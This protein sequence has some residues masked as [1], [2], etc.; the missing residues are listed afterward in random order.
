MH[1]TCVKKHVLF[2]FYNLLCH[3]SAIRPSLRFCN[4]AIALSTF[5]NWWKIIFKEEEKSRDFPSTV[6]I[7]FQTPLL[8]PISVGRFWCHACG[9][10][11]MLFGG[12][13]RQQG[14]E[15][16]HQRSKSPWCYSYFLLT[17]KKLPLYSCLC[18]GDLPNQKKVF[19]KSGTSL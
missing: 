5:C 13:W 17:I 2:L 4:L 19:W 9:I 7:L 12:L 6:F 8:F 14:W 18:Q 16:W 15:D 1:K 10:K 3:F 11:A